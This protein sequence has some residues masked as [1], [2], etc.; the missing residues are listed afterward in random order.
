[1]VAM[2]AEEIVGGSAAA[3][4][5]VGYP[6]RE[7]MVRAS[8]L[9]IDPTYQRE[10]RPSWV[11][12]IA[13]GF[14]PFLLDPL[15]VSRRRDGVLAVMDGQHRLLAIR[16]IGY[17]DQMVPC[18]VYDNL[19]IDQ[20]ARRFNTQ[21][22]RRALKPQQRMRSLLVE[23][24]PDALTVDAEVRRA[25][26][27]INLV[28]G[29]CSDGQ[30]C[31]VSALFKIVRDAKP[32]DLREVLELVRDGFGT[33]EGPRYFVLAGIA[34]FHAKYRGRYDRARL[35]EAMRRMTLSRLAAEGTDY[36]R[37]AK[38][39]TAEGVGRALVAAYNHRRPSRNQLPAWDIDGRTGR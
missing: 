33:G 35:V 13:D 31:A 23:G 21:D 36:G 22:A 29:D 11:A 1:M 25:G 27:R 37:V 38:V 24:D 9:A 5:V 12:A 15:L 26:F 19:P 6:Y 18:L 20:E 14:D 3:E 10:V 2:R 34:R 28:D 17:G 32:G 30:I 7:E 4:A 8:D 39:T 16:R